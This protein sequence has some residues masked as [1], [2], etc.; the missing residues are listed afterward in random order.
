MKVKRFGKLFFFK[1]GVAIRFDVV[2]NY[3]NDTDKGDYTFQ[4]NQRINADE[5]AFA[6]AA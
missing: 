1:Y 4:G 6:M 5:T 3:L 2:K